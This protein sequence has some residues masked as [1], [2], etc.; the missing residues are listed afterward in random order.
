METRQLE[1]F[2]AVV[3]RRSFS[4]AAERLGV[5]QPAVSLQIQALEKRLGTKL[6][7]R[8]GRRVEPTEAGMRLYRGAQ[9]LLALEEQVVAEVAEEATAEL[10]GR[11]EIRERIAAGG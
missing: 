7:D 1:T 8:S 10:E 9:R 2:V 3:E 11:F 6:L 5:T 4:Q